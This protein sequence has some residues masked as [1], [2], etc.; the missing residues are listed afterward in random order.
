MD[1]ARPTPAPTAPV[2]RRST[3]W[4]LVALGLLALWRAW[5]AAAP[6]VA[7]ASVG[8]AIAPSLG[9]LAGDEFRLLPGVGPVLAGRL[10]AARLAA[11]GRLRAQDLDSVPGIGP[12][13]R[14][15]WT[16]AGWLRE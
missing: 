10:E 5:L 9:A 14:Q 8:T 13:L 3:G 7:P 4:V 6:P 15:R 2:P 11:G 16:A 12:A 1:T